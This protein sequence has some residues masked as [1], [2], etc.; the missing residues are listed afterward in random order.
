MKVRALPIFLSVLVSSL[1]LFGGWYVFQNQFVKKPISNEI[2]AMQS[3]K[4]NNITVGRDAITLNVS[5]NDPEKFAEDYKTIKKIASDKANGK[6]VKIECYSPNISLQK[7]WEENA[8]AVAEAME[9]HTYSKIPIAL[10]EM[11]KKHRLKNA[12]SYMDEQNVYIYLNDGKGPYYAVLPR[13]R[14][15]SRNG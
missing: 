10:E 15:V 12:T 3:V 2:A 13:E 11:K 4:L 7:I 8:F 5:F 6:T 14:E 9:L 1:L